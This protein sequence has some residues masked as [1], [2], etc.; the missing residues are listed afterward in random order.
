MT[1][2]HRNHLD[3]Y[4]S[5][6][7]FMR[8]VWRRTEFGEPIPISGEVASA[9]NIPLYEYFQYSGFTLRALD[10][11]GFISH[12]QWD[13]EDEAEGRELYEGHEALNIKL[14]S[15]MFGVIS[16]PIASPT[17]SD[18]S[19]L[20]VRHYAHLMSRHPRLFVKWSALLAHEN[21]RD[22][23]TQRHESDAWLSC[24]IALANMEGAF[25]IF[26]D[27]TSITERAGDILESFESIGM[28]F[29][30]A[31]PYIR[32]GVIDGTIAHQIDRVGL[33]ID[34]AVELSRA[35]FVV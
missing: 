5:T 13:D 27:F 34:F 20:E 17:T 33:S 25:D 3:E 2:P 1:L 18:E 14:F 29:D 28:S 32:I 21:W 11:E 23:Q 16:A 9:W 7:E 8:G 35:K 6:N 24:L 26:T 12:L 30:D 15:D 31:A 19:A 10:V 4:Q 22:M